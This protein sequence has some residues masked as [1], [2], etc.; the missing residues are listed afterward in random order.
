MSERAFHS[1]L[2]E[3]D[4]GCFEPERYELRSEPGFQPCEMSRRAF[5]QTV[6]VGLV[7][8]LALGES[9]AAD[10]APRGAP[11]EIGAWI[12]ID[13]NSR[14]TVF[15][16]KVEVGQ[17]IRTSLA[18]AVAEELRA[19]MSSIELVMGDTDL[20]PYDMGTFG[21]RS[22]PDMGSRLQKAAAAARELLRDLAAA[23]WKVDRTRLVVRDGKVTDPVTGASTPIGKLTRGEKLVKTILDT[24][25]TTPADRWTIEGT[26]V[27]RVTGHEM[28]T[29]KHRYAS[30][31]MRPGMLH[32]SVLRAD[33]LNASLVNADTTAAAAMPGVTVVRDG[34]FIGVTAPDTTTAADAVAAIKSEW[35]APP[36]PSSTTIYDYLKTHSAESS[37]WERGGARETGSVDPVFAAGK[38]LKATYTIAYIA[39]TPMEPRAAVAEWSNGKLTVWTGTQRPFGVRSELATTFQI[40][41][42]Q[43]HVIMPDTG[44]GY[45][46]KHTGEV[47]VE[48]ARLAKAVGKPVKVRWTREE[49]FTWAY[50][51]PAGVIDVTSVAA[52][53]GSITAW[54]FHN[55]NSGSSGIGPPYDIPNQRIE[56]HPA[57]SPLRQGSYRALAASA[58]HF[59]RESH[60]DEL[61]HSVK[62]DPLKFRLRNLKDER[63]LAA[64]NA[65]ADHFGWDKRTP[66][67][68]YGMACGTEK[69]SFLSTFAEV[70]IEGP[71][72]RVRVHRL[73]T[74]FDCGAIVNPAELRSQIEGA[75]MMGL[76]G[77]LFEA[78][79]FE[80]GK[81]LNGRLSEYRVPRFSDMPSIEAVLI[82][83]KDQPSAGAGET[84]LMLI[85]AAIGNAIFNATG[86]RLRSMPL[87]PKGVPA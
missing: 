59:A 48:A 26:S 81:I 74:A 51:R 60:I 76:G 66:G 5:L 18:Q 46:G 84:G 73:V 41:E 13:E 21:S 61:A 45:G 44:G 68:G 31:I 7:V 12:H 1:T 65:G 43:V 53:D 58:N 14:I 40:P 8:V 47:A 15:T 72:R 10:A 28:V 25:P 2:I 11:Q 38:P 35:K 75:A 27:P 29:G 30:N 83:R 6:G 33:R 62:M 77:A 54:E 4:E 20:T 37:G 34:D 39:H 70:G 57:K 9:P 23:Q 55:Y 82:D 64:V 78:M 16:G 80:N 85:P 49:E 19:P 24:V 86:V 22:T 3:A 87:A 56:F 42:E 17:G 50:F 67:L 32:G 79:R 36:Q 52:P 63:L 71:A 69:G